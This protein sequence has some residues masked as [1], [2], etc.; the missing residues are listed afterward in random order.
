MFLNHP[1]EFFFSA[2]E[3]F[4]SA[5]HAGLNN[6]LRSSV[7]DDWMSSKIQVVV[8]TVAFGYDQIHNFMTSMFGV[9]DFD[10]YIFSQ[11]FLFRNVLIDSHFRYLDFLLENSEF[12]LNSEFCNFVSFGGNN[13]SLSAFLNFFVYPI[14]VD[15]D[16]FV[17]FHIILLLGAVPVTDQ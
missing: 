5:Y 2:C 16:D 11:F 7:L 3:F 6:K 14:T 8:A 12:N 9:L 15:C 10:C 1:G 13:L 17:C 4:F